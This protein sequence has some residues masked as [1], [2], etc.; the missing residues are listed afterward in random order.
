[1]SRSAQANITPKQIQ[2]GY[3]GYSS[4]DSLVLRDVTVMCAVQFL[5]TIKC[6][7]HI[8]ILSAFLPCLPPLTP[9]RCISQEEVLGFLE[10]LPLGQFLG[11]TTLISLIHLKSVT[12]M[13]VHIRHQKCSAK[14]DICFLRKVR[15]QCFQIPVFTNPS[16]KNI[17]EWTSECDDS[18]SKG[19]MCWCPEL[20]PGTHVKLEGQTHSTRLHFDLYMCTVANTHT[21]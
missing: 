18:A 1:M 17:M 21:Q 5:S 6:W 20:M 11:K 13:T 14:A 10:S 2:P 15:C 7:P 16:S 19:R 3:L 9:V 4:S 8:L 12:R